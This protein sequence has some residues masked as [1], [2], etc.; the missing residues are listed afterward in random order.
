[1]VQIHFHLVC[2]SDD[3]QFIMHVYI[4]YI[5]GMDAF[6][7]CKLDL[8]YFLLLKHCD[9]INKIIHGMFLYRKALSFDKLKTVIFQLQ[10]LGFM[11][12]IMKI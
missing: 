8:Q 7:L 6:L 10:R 1:M 4:F 12:K 2:R 9:Y 11:Q 5:F 3:L